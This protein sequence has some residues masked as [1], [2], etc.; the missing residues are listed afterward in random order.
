MGPGKGDAERPR[1]CGGT[2]LAPTAPNCPCSG[3]YL[4]R[5]HTDTP[6]LPTLVALQ[7]LSEPQKAP[8]WPAPP[9]P[10]LEASAEMRLVAA[11]ALAAL[12]C[13]AGGALAGESRQRQ[14]A[15]AVPRAFGSLAAGT[16]GA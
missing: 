11:V 12:V 4:P 5:K 14:Q 13:L 15:P 6:P 16:G 2:E 1:E 9:V 7:Q 10:R 8:H 3:Y